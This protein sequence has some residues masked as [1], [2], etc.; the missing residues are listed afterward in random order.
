M[1]RILT[2]DDSRAVRMIVA[3]HA[4][5]FGFEV[6]EAED[7]E[8]GLVRL[9]TEK[10]DLVVLD[11]T[12]PVLDGPGMLAKL[13]E[14]GD[15][16]PILML[17]SESKR[18][19]IASL[20]KLGIVDYILKPFKPEELQA[21]ILKALK[22]E[23]QA[24]GAPATT[25]DIPRPSP[26][27]V[28]APDATPRAEG[29]KPFGDILVVDDMDNVAKRL[30][31]LTPEHLTLQGV[32]TAAQALSTCREKVFRVILVDSDIPDTNSASLMKQL[33]LLQPHAGFLLLAL[34]TTNNIQAEARESG[35]DSVLFKP[36][37]QEGIEEFLLRYFDNQE[38]V[39]KDDNILRMA[40]FKGRENRLVGYFTQVS[41]ISGKAVEEIAAAC[42]PDVILEMSQVPPI[43]E[44]VARLV[45]ELNEKAKK[46]GVELRIVGNDDVTKALSQYTETSKIPIFRSVSEAQAAGAA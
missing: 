30:R 15:M 39:A 22:M 25:P 40:A 41:A 34:R 26:A 7:G 45:I 43:A 2:V 14:R 3:K 28:A 46:F 38:L 11:V 21:K 37:T 31:Q 20:M 32:T 27:A 5:Q 17:T 12:M 9:E 44:K 42:F 24:G 29:G 10:F 13:R 18:S 23:G 1:P 36:F 8:Q 4:R 16:T 35:F 33:R 6:E 19:I